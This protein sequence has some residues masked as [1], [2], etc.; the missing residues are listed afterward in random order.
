MKHYA[1][2][3]ESC[4]EMFRRALADLGIPERDVKV[5]WDAHAGWAR[6]RC[7]LPS[8]A[9]VDRTEKPEGDL[10]SARYE[11]AARGDNA[12]PR[13]SDVALTTLARWLKATAKTKP[14][15]LDA[16]FVEHIAPKA[17]AS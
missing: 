4:I 5:T 9:I 1:I 8:G 17:V 15:D 13:A 16:A 14:V 3:V 10:S 11:R 6:F 12:V 2:S 7:K